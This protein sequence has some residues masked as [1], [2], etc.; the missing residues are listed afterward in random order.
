MP[1][2]ATPPMVADAPGWKLAPLIVTAVPPVVAP[3]VGVTELTVGAG[4]AS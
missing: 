3:L 4:D 2:S 1:V